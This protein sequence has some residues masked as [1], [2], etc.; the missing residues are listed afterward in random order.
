MAAG[1][2]GGSDG[3]VDACRT[4]T[5]CRTERFTLIRD[6]YWDGGGAD[7]VCT[8]APSTCPVGTC[9]GVKECL[10]QAGERS[11]LFRCEADEDCASGRCLPL[12]DGVGICL[13]S[14]S[15]DEDCPSTDERSPSP[16]GFGCGVIEVR[17]VTLQSCLPLDGARPE[18]TLCARD[19]DCGASGEGL[20]CRFAGRTTIR[21]LLTLYGLAE[22]MVTNDSGPAHFAALSTIDVVTLF[23]PE[24]PK[25]FSALTPRNHTLWAGLAC[26]P[27]I[28]AFNEVVA[29]HH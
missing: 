17:G 7:L 27:C 2:G 11:G 25:L 18:A 21:Q 24:T 5:D 3:R 22:V 10:P 26:S 8:V 15:N 1:G 4:S 29:L 28:N 13:R 20:G 9:P 6:L 12:R 19:G 23:G 16:W 14:C